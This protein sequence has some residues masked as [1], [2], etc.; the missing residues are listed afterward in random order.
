[1]LFVVDE[2]GVVQGL[3][4]P[5]DLLE[6]IT[7]ELKPTAPSDAWAIE[8]ADGLWIIDGTMPIAEF[9]SR[10]RVDNDLPEEDKARYNTVAGLVMSVAGRMLNHGDVV[11][12]P[13]LQ[14]IV[15][16]MAG[17]RVA[18]LRVKRTVPSET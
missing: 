18:Q 8:Q 7:G 1:M 3:L 2:Y 4:T 6:A 14:F 10:L 5:R 13:G 16:T 17:R 9:K 11:D 12:T 15:H